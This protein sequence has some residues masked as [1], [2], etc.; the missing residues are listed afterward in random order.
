MSGFDLVYGL[1]P[2]ACAIYFGL[3]EIANAIRN[4]NLTVRFERPIQIE[5]KP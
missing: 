2:L 1:F 3:S 5:S 4:R